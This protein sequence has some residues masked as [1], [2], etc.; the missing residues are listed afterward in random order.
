MAQNPVQSGSYRQRRIKDR[1]GSMLTRNLALLGIAAAAIA[2]ALA[3]GAPA[4]PP[5]AAQGSPADAQPLIGT[6]DLEQC[7]DK[8][9]YPYVKDVNADLEKVR[10]EMSAEVK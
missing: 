8:D 5:A 6:V 10:A 7:F 1:R 2:A 9:K 4:L 3:S